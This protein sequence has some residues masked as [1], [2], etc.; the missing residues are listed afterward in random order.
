MQDAIPISKPVSFL[1]LSGGVGHRSGYAEPKQFFELSGHPVI[2][3]SIIAAIHV[4]QI[5]EILVNAPPGFEERTAQIMEAYCATVPFRL[6]PP[7]ATRQ[8]SSRNL[9]EAASYDRVIMH[10]AARPFVTRE[11][12]Q[13]LVDGEYENAGYCQG[14]PFSMCQIDPQ[15]REITAGVPRDRTFN[16]QLPQIFSRETLRSAHESA[17][18]ENLSYTE[19][20]VMCVER[21]GARVLA[22][23][24]NSHNVKITT[25]EDFIIAEQIMRRTER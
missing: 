17:L 11:M 22:L 5:A 23:P 19:D 9:T 24:G 25:Q 21:V 13:A 1:L 8:E 20:A 14:I 7:G 4:P 16:I 3:Y 12:L 10:E 18:R 6:L 15:S 2:A